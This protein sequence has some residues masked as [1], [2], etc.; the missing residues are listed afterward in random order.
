MPEIQEFSLILS[1]F[2]CLNHVFL[3]QLNSQRETTQS[4]FF[5]SQNSTHL[6]RK[7]ET[8]KKL[9]INYLKVSQATLWK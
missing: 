7:V 5:S 9:E 8:E 4:G 6:Q 3:L 2:F 1:T